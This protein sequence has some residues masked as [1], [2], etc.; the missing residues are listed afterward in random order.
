MMVTYNCLE[1]YEIEFF[2]DFLLYKI[3][4]V[5]KKGIDYIIKKEQYMLV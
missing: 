3:Y 5:D 4:K 1:N 2:M